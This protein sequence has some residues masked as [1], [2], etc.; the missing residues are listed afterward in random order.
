MLLEKCPTLLSLFEEEDLDERRY[1][2]VVDPNVEEEADEA[3][4]IDPTE[5]NWMIFLPERV[6]E[7]FGEELFA[8]IPR[9]L[10]KVEVFE[11]FFDAEEDLYG[12]QCDLDEESIA[13]KVMDVLES[14][15]REKVK[16]EV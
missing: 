15:A 12:V 6:R 5:Y 16:E 8:R 11:D 2:A 1:F 10:A 14:L 3:D 4:V 13:W 9:E 7:A